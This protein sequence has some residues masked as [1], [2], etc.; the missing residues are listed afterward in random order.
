VTVNASAP[1][2]ETQ[3]AELVARVK[4]EVARAVP[5]GASVLVISKG[6]AA[7]LDMPGLRTAHFPQDPAGGY[8]G[9]Y[10]VDS[11]AATAAFEDLTR[12]GAEYL[13]IP[14]TARWWLDYYEGFAR[15]LATHLELVADRS[16]ACLIYG[17]GHPSGVVASV[18]AI[19]SPQTSID[20]LRDFLENLI[21]ADAELAVL[22][23]NAPIA[24]ALAPLHA[25]P[26]HAADMREHNG[27]SLLSQLRLLVAEGAD[28]LVVP[29]AEEDLLDGHAE[30]N[31]SIEA[32][33]RKVADQRNLCRV[34]DLDGFRKVGG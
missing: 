30:L 4:M 18:P 6:D 33:L 32:S 21:A 12:R 31:A 17:I 24:S 22:E 9:H 34:F 26:L 28:Y 1:L 2:S 23:A 14:A 13:V 7:L 11:A 15:H 27:E 16:D 3:Y 10:P 19:A 5:P 29:T 20:Q 25:V 8:A